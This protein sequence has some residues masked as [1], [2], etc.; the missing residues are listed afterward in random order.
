M[1]GP[2]QPFATK[3]KQFLSQKVFGKSVT[4]KWDEMDRFHSIV[5]PARIC[6]GSL[7]AMSEAI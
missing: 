3:A 7:L 1:H 5:S 4:V 2:R 6:V